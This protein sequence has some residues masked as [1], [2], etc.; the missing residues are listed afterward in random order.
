MKIEMKRCEWWKKRTG[1]SE[2]EKI[3][4]ILLSP[5]VV[6]PEAMFSLLTDTKTF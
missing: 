4:I 3:K 5:I 1:S 2:T 6:G